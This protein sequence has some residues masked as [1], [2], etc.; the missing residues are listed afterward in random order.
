MK[1][2]LFS[3]VVFSLLLFL[4]GCGGGSDSGSSESSRSPYELRMA[5]VEVQQ[6]MRELMAEHDLDEH[7][8]VMAAEE[9][10]MKVAEEFNKARR[11]H[12][13]LAPLF[14][15]S[16]R[17]RNQAVQ[18][19]I[20]GDDAAYQE[21][22][23]AYKNVRSELERTAGKLPEMEEWKAR[24]KE[25]E[26]ETTLAMADVVAEINDRGEELAEQLR[27]LLAELN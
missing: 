10:M 5:M 14:E 20:D 23:D 11:E 9:K 6:E 16:D 1:T 2:T 8:A 25:V 15:V 27:D 3:L 13:T 4:T 18:S 17:H 24:L 21:H 22:M 12:P 26:N 7:P 19:R